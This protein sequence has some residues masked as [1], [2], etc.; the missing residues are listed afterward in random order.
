MIRSAFILGLVA[1]SSLARPTRLAQCNS[2]KT[3]KVELFVEATDGGFTLTSK[4]ADDSA[5]ER[6]FTG[7]V[8]RAAHEKLD[9]RHHIYVFDLEDGQLQQARGLDEKHCHDQGARA[10]CRIGAVS[11]KLA[12]HGTR[13]PGDDGMIPLQDDQ[14]VQMDNGAPQNCTVYASKALRALLQAGAPH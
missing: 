14:A 8:V 11:V 9:K 10:S 3:G 12:R 4:D 13:G 1:A 2:G 5:S 7:K 6:I